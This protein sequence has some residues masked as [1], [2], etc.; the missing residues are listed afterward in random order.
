MAHAITNRCDQCDTCVPLC[1]QGAI[2]I[3][4]SEY[5]I[6]PTL[7]NDCEDY[8]DE[9][10][11]A[12]S[13][14][15]N[16]PVPW[17]AKK[18]RLK[19]DG[20]P[21]SNTPL[22]VNGKN[23][24]FASAIV[25]WELCNVLAQRQTLPWQT[26]ENGILYYGRAI[27]QNRGS[28]SFRIAETLEGQSSAPLSAPQAGDRIAALDIRAACLHLLYSAYATTLEQPWQESFEIDDRQIELYLGLDKRK[29]LSKIA[30]LSLIKELV[31]QPCSLMATIDWPQQGKI[32]AFHLE[33]IRLWHLQSTEHHFQA[34]ELG[35]KHLVGMT[36]RI[37][38]GLWTQYFLNRKDCKDRTAFYQY[39][40]LPHSLL[41][42]V[43]GLW[44]Q[45]EGAVRMMLWLLFKTKVGKEQR[46]TVPTLMR[47]A[48]G[49]S[50]VER[51]TTGREERKRLLRTFESDLEVL[52][53]HGLRPVFDPVTYPEDIQPLWAKLADLPDDAEEALEFWTNDG[54]LS[55]RLTDS[56]PRGK[57]NRLMNARLIGFEVPPDWEQ[58]LRKPERKPER[59]R[60]NKSRSSTSP[61]LARTLLEGKHI[62]A[63]RQTLGWS[64]R[65]LALKTGK[66][67]SWIRDIE[68]GRFSAKPKDQTLLKQIL[69]IG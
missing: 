16:S 32:R 44:Q 51:A 18:G 6:D 22:F 40:S 66:S 68:N 50:K 35:Y 34:D 45:H 5:W 39:S 52:N 15:V 21:L 61:P 14:P 36:F 10:I 25:S 19:V 58:N 63:A 48:Y 4:G 13:C 42:A 46:I 26:D 7:C 17:Q 41:T 1:P 8:A 60:S 29:D 65:D 67:Q 54:T 59:K 38:A 28:I 56:G 62:T 33:N 53:H 3:I 20:R 2:K 23:H 27:T 43:M 69:G 64:Q 24:P 30:K 11:C 55:N 9:P 57:W 49:T 47:V 31:E 37:Q 12:I